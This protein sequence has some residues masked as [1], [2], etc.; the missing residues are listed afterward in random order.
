MQSHVIMTEYEQGD[1]GEFEVKQNENYNLNY[2]SAI[3]SIM[4]KPQYHYL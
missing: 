3:D 1:E 4:V 2:V